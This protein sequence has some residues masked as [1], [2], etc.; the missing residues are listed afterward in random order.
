MVVSA[1]FLTNAG[2][3]RMFPGSYRFSS[4]ALADIDVTEVVT[5]LSL[6]LCTIFYQELPNTFAPVIDLHHR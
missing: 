1:M 3:G 4:L 2:S 6:E 5:H